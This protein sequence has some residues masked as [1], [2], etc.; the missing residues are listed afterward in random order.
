MKKRVPDAEQVSDFMD[1]LIHPMKAEVEKLRAI[2]NGANPKIAER[3]K[4]NA[5]S[6]YYL[7]DV[8]AFNLRQQKFVQLILLFPEGLLS[9]SYGIL[10]GDW[11]DRREARFYGIEDIE[12]KSAALQN[13][14]NDWVALAD[15]KQ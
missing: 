10:E 11:K 13:L 5:P 15:S 6:Y 14:I 1:A 2:I 8:A 4:W 3:I 7:K 9:H 12:T